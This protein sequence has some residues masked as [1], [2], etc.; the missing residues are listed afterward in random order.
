MGLYPKGVVLSHVSMLSYST[1]W[2]MGRGKSVFLGNIQE[3][4]LGKIV[5]FGEVE[6]MVLLVCPIPS[7]GDVVV[8][9]ASWTVGTNLFNAWDRIWWN[10]YVSNN[11]GE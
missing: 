1:L 6:D 10:S 9:L 11:G 4:G 2:A 5:A 7:D 8:W 3:R